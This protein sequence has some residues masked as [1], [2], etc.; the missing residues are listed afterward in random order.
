MKKLEIEIRETKDLS[1]QQIVEINGL[2]QQHWK[3]SEAE[4]MRW[5]R[6]NIKQDDKHVLLREGGELA[7]YLNLV[8]VDVKISGKTIKMLGIG[9]VCVS[10]TK[11][12]SGMGAVLMAVTNSYLKRKKLCG[13]LFCRDKVVGFY[14]RAGWEKVEAREIAVEEKLC[15]CNAMIYDPLRTIPENIEKISVNRDF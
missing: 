11:E 4:H 6:E 15:D 2:K 9:N 13:I 8:N 3:Y 7:A 5:F 12:G 10:V 14:I 1:E